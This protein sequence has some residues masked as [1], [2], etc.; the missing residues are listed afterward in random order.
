MDMIANE[1]VRE[2]ADVANSSFLFANFGKGAVR[3]YDALENVLSELKLENAIF[4]KSTLL[5]KYIATTTQVLNISEN[6]LG[7]ITNHLGHNINVHKD[8]YR[9]IIPDNKLYLYLYIL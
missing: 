7:W 9:V 5:R 4:I 2:L 3:A 1:D 8:F 6:Q